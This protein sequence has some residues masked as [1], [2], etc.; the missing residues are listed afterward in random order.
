M[1]YTHV[2]APTEFV[3]TDSIRF[4]YRRFGKEVGVP[5]VLMPHFRA[6]M[7]HW[8]PAVTDGFA[9]ERQVILFDNAGVAGTTGQTPSTFEAMGDYASDFV[10]A[11]GLSQVDILGF[12]IG[13]YIAQTMALRH[14]KIIRRLIL[15]GTG[16]RN[17]EPS[18]DAN[19]PPLAASTDPATGETGLDAFLYLFFSPSPRGQALGGPSGND[20]T[21][22]RPTSMSRVPP[23]RWRHSRR[24]ERS[25]GGRE[26]NDLL[27]CN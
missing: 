14:S 5:L 18:T 3:E 15:V 25:G 22:G 6:G 19:Y 9:V 10:R 24:R 4:A 11:L 20:D 13:G 12:S 17:G 21:V 2:T 27:S 16:P 26:G 8:D 23:R 7:D 1:S